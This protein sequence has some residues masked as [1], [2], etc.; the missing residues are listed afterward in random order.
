M[1][2]LWRPS[3][4]APAG[5]G[6]VPAC[7]SH[8]PEA[9]APERLDCLLV[10]ASKRD[11]TRCVASGTGMS[12]AGC[13]SRTN[14]YS[15]RVTFVLKALGPRSYDWAGLRTS[16]GL[17]PRALRRSHQ[18]HMRRSHCRI[19]RRPTHVIPCSSDSSAHASDPGARSPNH[20]SR[21]GRAQGLHHHRCVCP[22]W[23]RRPPDW[24]GSPTSCRG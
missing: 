12:R 13:P 18:S 4:V 21:H 1:P 5:D 14:I 9:T 17:I 2:S 11:A 23:Q 24:K 20:L 22:A 7:A 6:L 15:E 16:R 10:Q 19:T 8:A 3:P